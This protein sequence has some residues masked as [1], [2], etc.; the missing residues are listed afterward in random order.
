MC[1]SATRIFAIP[2]LLGALIGALLGASTAQAQQ[3]PDA[4]ELARQLQQ[5]AP[6]R[7]KLFDS[8]VQAAVYLR[9][10]LEAGVSGAQVRRAYRRL[11]GAVGPGLSRAKKKALAAPLARLALVLPARLRDEVLAEGSWEQEPARWQF[12]DEAGA[13]LLAW[14]RSQ[15]PLPATARNERLAEHLRRVAFSLEH[16]G[17]DQHLMGFDDRGETYVQYGP[18][19]H[20]TEIPLRPEDDPEM[21]RKTR[22]HKF[23]DLHTHYVNSRVPPPRTLRPFE[24]WSYQNI[25]ADAYFLFFNKKGNQYLSGGIADLYADHQPGSAPVDAILYEEL[26]F[27]HAE[28]S[29]RYSAVIAS[30]T[31]PSEAPFVGSFQQA[32]VK[33][34][35]T[36]RRREKLMPP[37]HSSLLE[38]V[39][40]L[41]VAHRTARF[42]EEDGTTRAEIY[43]APEPGALSFGR[44]AQSTLAQLGYPAPR[45]YLLA[46]YVRV[47]DRLYRSDTT[48]SRGRV[49]GPKD[50]GPGQ[51]VPTQSFAVPGLSGRFHLSMQF[52]QRLLRGDA[53]AGSGPRVRL[54]TAQADSM[55][56]LPPASG[57]LA[58]SD[59]R[60]MLLPPRLVGKLAQGQALRKQTRPLAYPFEKILPGAPLALYFEAYH[61]G[62]GAEDRTR[63]TVEYDIYRRTEAGGLRGLFGGDDEQRTTTQATYNGSTSTTHEVIMLDLSEVEVEAGSELVVTVRVTDEVLGKTQERSVRFTVVEEIEQKP[64]GEQAPDPIAEGGYY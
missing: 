49:L 15:D 26:G 37:Q 46:G 43:W 2:L 50:V 56:A 54:T 19:A 22:R 9:Q 17:Y 36:R 35:Q 34:W 20:I 8:E 53:Q 48:R 31:N 21:G 41:E 60:P 24:L 25:D 23:M 29:S 32:D 52:E 51:T 44:K 27:V 3:L 55:T 47:Y 40:R 14:W 45:R 39:N 18:P 28:F 62:F 30:K 11:L 13:R 33:D 6:E 5:A 4:E 10:M 16:Y 7:V 58:M 57:G 59:L 42:L 1:T 63:Y 64:R 38:E 12:A 61:L